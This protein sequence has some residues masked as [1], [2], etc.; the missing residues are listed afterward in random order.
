MLTYTF[1]HQQKKKKTEAETPRGRPL[2]QQVYVMCFWGSKHPTE[3]LHHVLT[4]TSKQEKKKSPA[5]QMNFVGSNYKYMYRGCRNVWTY[6]ISK[7]R[8]DCA[9]WKT[10]GIFIIQTCVP[11]LSPF[12]WTARP[13][14]RLAA[15]LS[16]VCSCVL[17]FLFLCS[18][19]TRDILGNLFFLDCGREMQL[20]KR[21]V[22]FCFFVPLKPDWTDCSQ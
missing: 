19:E 16:L 20:E 11:L 21:L 18:G 8:N 4:I 7:L 22:L 3:K 9:Q 10:L 12:L 17:V 2:F 13:I 14:K 6:C 15:G 5:H 1:S